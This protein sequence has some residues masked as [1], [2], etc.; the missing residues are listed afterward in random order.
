[1]KKKLKENIIK[2]S[3]KGENQIKCK[4]KEIFLSNIKSYFKFIDPSIRV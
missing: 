1:M 2:K 4:I 3:V